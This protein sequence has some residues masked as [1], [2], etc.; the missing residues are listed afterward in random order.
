ML[1]VFFFVSLDLSRD[2]NS[3]R[4]I[5]ARGQNVLFHQLTCHRSVSVVRLLSDD[6]ASS[7]ATGSQGGDPQCPPGLHPCP[8]GLQPCRVGLP[9]S[10]RPLWTLHSLGPGIWDS[11][12]LTSGCDASFLTLSLA[13]LGRFTLGYHPQFHLNS[14]AQHSISLHLSHLSLEP[15]ASSGPKR[16][17]LTEG[18]SGTSMLQNTRISTFPHRLAPYLI[19]LVRELRG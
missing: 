3:S 19:G 7:P 8:A 16:H 18:S 14:K 9:H 10:D 13:S 4:I 15:W 12:R 1:C 6:T 2:L 5:S 11:W 17:V